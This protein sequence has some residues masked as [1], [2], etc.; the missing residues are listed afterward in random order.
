M[1]TLCHSDSVCVCT[2]KCFL[3]VIRHRGLHFG[4]QLNGST[5][6]EVS[7]RY[8]ALTP[9]VWSFNNFASATRVIYWAL[10]LLKPP[11]MSH[12]VYL[13]TLCAHFYRHITVVPVRFVISADRLLPNPYLLPIQHHLAP[14]HCPHNL[15]TGSAQNKANLNL[16]LRATRRIVT[17]WVELVSSGGSWFGSRKRRIEEGVRNKKERE[18]ERERERWREKWR[19]RKFE[20]VTGK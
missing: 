20:R 11:A 15:G 13:S 18:R 12:R 3:Y 5:R 4:Q 16:V 6:F 9:S 7:E 10:Q 14:S 17:S 19:T 2:G 1:T 8:S